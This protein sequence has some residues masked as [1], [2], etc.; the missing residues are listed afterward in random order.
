M[1]AS[2]HQSLLNS[3]ATPAA[4]PGLFTGEAGIL[5]FFWFWL[6][7]NTS[8]HP[9]FNHTEQQF[10]QRLNDLLEEISRKQLLPVFGNGTAGIGWLMELLLQE[11]TAPYTANFNKN[12]EHQQ[13][14]MLSKLDH[15]PG[16]LEL[17]RGVAGEIVLAT[18]RLHAL[19]EADITGNWLRHLLRL[20][21]RS[22]VFVGTS[23]Y[24]PTP[25][26]SVFFQKHLP[27]GQVNLGHAHGMSGILASLIPLLQLP[28]F[29]DE[30]EL[31]LRAGCEWLL[32][33]QKTA[34]H[35]V[36]SSFYPQV[37]DSR[38]GWCYGDLTI[39]L[40]LHRAGIALNKSAWCDLARSIARNAANRDAVASCIADAG[41]CH[42]SMGL[43]LIFRLLAVQLQDKQL[44]LA[45]D[46]WLAWTCKK[47]Q[48]NGLV[49]LYPKHHQQDQNSLL[50]GLA[51]VGLVLLSE[52][53]Q[54]ASWVDALMLA[55]PV[56]VAFTDHTTNDQY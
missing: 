40:T 12:F 24:W 53:G 41:I 1:L 11:Q 44:H 46:Q 19:P 51:G 8:Q 15:W 56:I 33:Q 18:R 9:S 5:V 32:L 42:G 37:D 25:E 4:N 10:Q 34:G 20:L 13:L 54:T 55:D 48:Q 50:E 28:Q 23:C 26:H 14:Q 17:L 22:A 49:G 7:H 6:K 16:E 52:G 29:R 3:P 30:A 35:S 31:L 2:I 27:I 36:F 38:L 47:Y 45:A 43:V 21:R 39:A